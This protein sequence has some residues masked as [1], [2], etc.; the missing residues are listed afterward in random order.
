M[1]PN[2]THIRELPITEGSKEL[3]EK[4]ISLSLSNF[5][6]NLSS[7]I[8]F[9]SAAEKRMRKTSDI[10][11]LFVLKKF[12]LEEINEIRS[13]YCNA[14]A[15]AK[16][17]ILFILENELPEAAS[18]FP[19]KFSDIINRH[20]V[21]YGH[22]ALTGISIPAEDKKRQLAQMLLNLKIRLRERYAMLSLREEQLVHLIAETAAPLRTAAYTILEFHNEKPSSGK[23]ALNSIITQ[24]NDPS[25]N[26]LPQIFSRA[27]EQ[28]YLPSTDAN[29]SIFLIIE[30]IDKMLSMLK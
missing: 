25:L 3:I 11:L 8:L 28:V 20:V 13:A 4:L 21:I 18:Y 26:K 10:N 17:K 15:A 27:R 23:E 29:L 22:D 24:I 30:L 1:E 5:K 14:Y 12:Q 6:E 7:I 19:V 16:V 2:L 9:G